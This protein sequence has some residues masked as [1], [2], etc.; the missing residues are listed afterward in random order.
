[1]S[2]PNNE[3]R[4]AKDGAEVPRDGKTLGEIEFR[5]VGQG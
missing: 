4:V 3:M 2:Y 1:V 5:C